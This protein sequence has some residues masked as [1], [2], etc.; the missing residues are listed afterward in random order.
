MT[1]IIGKS[2]CLIACDIYLPYFIII[3][4]QGETKGKEIDLPHLLKMNP[5][6]NSYHEP[7]PPVKKAPVKTLQ[8][9]VPKSNLTRVKTTTKP[10]VSLES[11][12]KNIRFVFEFFFG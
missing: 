2:F 11:G 4:F 10:L 5:I 12:N 1:P 6:L 7:E 9:E 3:I 8:V